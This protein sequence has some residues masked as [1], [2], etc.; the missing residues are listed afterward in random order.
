[1]YNF[2]RKKGQKLKQCNP[3]CKDWSATLMDPGIR[4]RF[5]CF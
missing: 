3:C 1:M 4:T 2:F 5:L